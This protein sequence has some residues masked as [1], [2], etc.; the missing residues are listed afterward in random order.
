MRNHQ[1]GNPSRYRCSGLP[2]HNRYI[3][4]VT[5][6]VMSTHVPPDPLVRGELQNSHGV[7]EYFEACCRFSRCQSERCNPCEYA[8]DFAERLLDST[9]AFVLKR[10]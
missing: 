8:A 10:A 7:P 2:P 4:F 1:C 3:A 9:A 6:S 5:G